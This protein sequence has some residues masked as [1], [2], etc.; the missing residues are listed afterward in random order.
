M[1]KGSERAAL[2]VLIMALVTVI[3]RFLP[4]II[5]KDAGKTPAWVSY[6]G[7]VLPQAIIGMLVVYCL[8]TI[9]FKSAPF[10]VPE[11]ISC[12]VVAALQFWKNNSIISIVGGTV[13]YMVLIR[14][15]F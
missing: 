2:Y 6:L 13:A 10:G 9:S 14:V 8:R 3:L 4:F 12:A 7:K 11:L 1:L 5:F 15:V